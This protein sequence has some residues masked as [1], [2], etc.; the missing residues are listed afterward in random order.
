MAAG[1]EPA[2]G[3][4]ISE[5]TTGRPR[6][7]ARIMGLFEITFVGGVAAGAVLGGYLWKFFGSTVKIGHFDL[8]SPAFSVNGLVYL[9]S[10]AIFAWGLREYGQVSPVA[11]SQDGIAN[12]GMSRNPTN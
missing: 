5:A 8:I 6:L 4:Y 1:R 3:G 10:L 11:E 12:A 9:V 7:R 2:T